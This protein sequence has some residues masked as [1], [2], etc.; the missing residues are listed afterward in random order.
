MFARDHDKALSRLWMDSRV[1]SK[2]APRCK[3]ILN[4]AG[5]ESMTIGVRYQW[6]SEAS[7][8]KYV[9]SDKSIRARQL[10]TNS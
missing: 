7:T 8:E 10:P 2:V 3:R 1:N 9:T 5:L 4:A 6:A